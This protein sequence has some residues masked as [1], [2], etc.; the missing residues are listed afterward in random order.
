MVNTQ[1]FQTIKGALLPAATARNESQAPAYEFTPRHQLAQL[2]ATGC[3]SKTFYANAEDQLEQIG[4]LVLSLETSYV[5][6]TAVYARERGYMKDMPATLAAA[7]AVWDTGLLAQ[8]FPRVIDNGKMLRNFVQVVRSGAMGRKSLGSRPKKLVQNWLLNATEK[9]LLNAS[10]GNTPS[11]ADVVKMVHPKP[12]EAW[13]AAWFAWLIGKPFDAAALPPITQAFERYKRDAAK[14]VVSAELPD[15]PFQMLTALPL[16]SAQW[17]QIA[18]QGSWQMVRQNLNT[19]ARHGVFEQ[20]GMTKVIAK[21]LADAKAVAKARVMPYQLLAAYTASTGQVPAL[22]S[23][24]LQ[25]A[26][27]HSLANVPRFDGQVVVCPDVSG[28]MSSIVTGQ[29]GS[30]SSKV[31]CIDVAALVA[32]AVLRKNPQATVLP[33]EQKVVPL[34]LNPRDSVMT[35]A[36]K[37]ASIGGGGTSCSAPLAQLNRERAVVDLVIMVSDNESW[38]DASHRGATQTMKEWEA[39]KKRNPNARLVCI[40]IQPYR[41]SQAGERSDILNV[42]GFSDAVF[43]MVDQFARGKMNAEHWVG[44][45]EQITLTPQ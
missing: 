15:V 9:Q 28:S 19:F 27:E 36:K 30:A 4:N 10:V 3:L 8:V 2:A 45:I 34:T 25:D 21:I 42:G 39:L 41:T 5:A 32:A 17:A 7:L 44:E 26:L 22:V 40:D 20:P 6:K 14:G 18:R 43:G 24:A 1:L 29:R 13:R 37:L 31:R 16:N 33:F 23:E 12:T 38:M 35:N 11:L